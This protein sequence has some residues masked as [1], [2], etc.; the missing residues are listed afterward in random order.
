MRYKFTGSIPSKKNDLRANKKTGQLYPD[1]TYYQ[2]CS[3]LK[4]Q[5]LTSYPELYTH[6]NNRTELILAALH[7]TKTGDRV[8]D[9]DNKI[10]TVLDAMKFIGLIPEDNSKIIKIHPG[11]LITIESEGKSETVRELEKEAKEKLNK[12]QLTA[13]RKRNN[14]EL[15]EDNES[16]ELE[17]L[18][19]VIFQP[20][21]AW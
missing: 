18:E 12:K 8:Y 14:R 2:F 5:I 15:K 16:F 13:F 1:D 4:Q 17:F 10:T 3:R 19:S 11:G 9:I 20:L 7:C 21:K 6:L